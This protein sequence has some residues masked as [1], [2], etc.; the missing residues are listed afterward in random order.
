[1]SKNPFLFIAG[2]SGALVVAIGALGA[3]SLK[4]YLPPDALVSYETAV[5]YQ[6]YHTL[7]LLFIALWQQQNNTKLLRTAGWL[8]V[9]GIICFSGSVYFLSTKAVTGLVNI[10]F[11]GPVTPI[12]GLLFIAGWVI[13]AIA[14]LKK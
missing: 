12:G 10:S 7:A 2:I 11:L 8:F 3:H 4:P 5:R 9:A 14:A 13:V 1:M 6:F